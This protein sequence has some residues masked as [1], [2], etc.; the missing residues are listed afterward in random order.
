MS[1]RAA[2]GLAWSLWSIFAVS[3]TTAAVLGT[4][5]DAPGFN[6]SIAGGLALI[7]AFGAYATVGAIV[8][9]RRPTNA[10][11]WLFCAIGALVGFGALS[12]V[13]AH[14]ALAVAAARAPLGVGAAWVASW[15]WYP[16]LGMTIM[17]P[18]LLF[19]TGGPPSRG[20]RPVVWF[21]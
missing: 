16:L 5:T 6:G 4:T 15:Y 7:F 21:A 10:V 1:P 19:P 8:A 14:Y 3:I 20:W 12:Q 9:S 17:M 18:L 13:Y 11:G 2:R